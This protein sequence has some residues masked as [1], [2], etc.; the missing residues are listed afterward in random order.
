MPEGVEIDERLAGIA[1]SATA[2]DPLQRCQTPRDFLK[3]LQ[4]WLSPSADDLPSGAPTKGTL[5]FLV[6]LLDDLP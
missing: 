1:L 6:G 2:F 3:A 4:G 5:E